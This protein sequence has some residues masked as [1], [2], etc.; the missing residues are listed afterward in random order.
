MARWF[1]ALTDADRSI[2]ELSTGTARARVARLLLWL[3]EREGGPRCQLFSR[4]DLGAVLGLTTETAS[5]TM[6]EMKRQGH[7]SEPRV[8]EFI[9][10]I[11]A[12]RALTQ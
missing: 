7:L 10:D 1:K 5:R 12:L 2:T 3:A 11:A 4:E 9:F 8:N 6:A